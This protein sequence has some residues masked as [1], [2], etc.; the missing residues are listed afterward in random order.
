MLRSSTYNW[1][2]ANLCLSQVLQKQIGQLISEG[3]LIF[4]E[5][6]DIGSPLVF[7][8]NET[9]PFNNTCQYHS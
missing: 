1:F 2:L 5:Y 3:E 8:V 6:P 9:L 4:K 7:V